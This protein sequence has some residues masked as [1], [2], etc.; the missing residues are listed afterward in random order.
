MTDNDYRRYIRDY[1]NYECSLE[2]LSLKFDLEKCESCERYEL[3]EDLSD[4]A[5]GKLCESCRNDIDI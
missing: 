5:Y 2:E 4:G 1:L 3:E